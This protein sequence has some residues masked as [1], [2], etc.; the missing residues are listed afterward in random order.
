MATNMTFVSGTVIPSDWLNNVNTV[1]NGGSGTVTTVSVVTANGFGGTV[2]TPTTT[3]A[4]TLTTNLTGLLKGNGTAMSAAVAGTDYLAPPS[5]TAIVKANSG[6]ALANAVAG[7]DYVAPGGALGTPSSGTLTNCTFPTLNQN[8]TGSAASLS[9]SGQSGLLTFTG[10]T[11]TN[12]A[13]TVRDAADTILELGGS[14]TPTGTWTSMTFVTPVLGTP[15][16]GNLSNCTADGT[17]AVGFLTIPQ[18]IQNANY[19]TVLAD[20]GKQ[21]YRANGQTTAITWTIPANA[22]VAYPIGTSITFINDGTSASVT[23]AITTD[24]M[25]L[26]SSGTTGNRTLAVQGI[27]TATKVTATRWLISGVGLT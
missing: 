15:T 19:T 10:L 14:Y 16:S 7:T 27:A 8:T 5:G 26:A 9:I 3:P 21:I 20:S 23:I 2:A 12:R 4:I 18:N 13:K 25:V 24:T 1:V 6:G 17:N 11:V 22:S